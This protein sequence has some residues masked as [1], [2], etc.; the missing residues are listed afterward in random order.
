MEDAEDGEPGE[1][2]GK[3]GVDWQAGGFFVLCGEDD[4]GAEEECEEGHELSAA[5]DDHDV[6]EE[7]GESGGVTGAE[8]VILGESE[9]EDIHRNETAEGDASNDVNCFDTVAGGDEGFG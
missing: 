7:A 8:V 9:V 5:D 6:P 3:V 1:A 4:S 2:F